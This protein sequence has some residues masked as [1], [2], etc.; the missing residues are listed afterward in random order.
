MSEEGSPV[1]TND[2]VPIDLEGLMGDESVNEPVQTPEESPPA[3]EEAPE[4]KKGKG[5]DKSR[6]V[7]DETRAMARKNADTLD[8]MRAGFDALSSEMRNSLTQVVASLAAGGSGKAVD[9]GQEPPEATT[10]DL[11]AEL[12]AMDPDEV[13]IPEVIDMMRKALTRVNASRDDRAQLRQ[14]LE[15]LRKKDQTRDGNEAIAAAQASVRSHIGGLE[16]THFKGKREHRAEMI[17]IAQDHCAKM[18]FDQGNNPPPAST[19]MMALTAAAQA[20]ATREQKQAQKDAEV[21]AD[22]LGGGTVA[23]LGDKHMTLKEAVAEMGL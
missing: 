3:K 12:D 15:S 10:D 20:I 17:Q 13:D 5:W 11:M 4:D 9:G 8:E 1:D 7:I 23:D 18:G 14:Q 19:A 21:V 6:Q 16:R 2:A 22:S